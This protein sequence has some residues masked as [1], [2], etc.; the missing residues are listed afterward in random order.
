MRGQDF[1]PDLIP[2]SRPEIGDLE[3]LGEPPAAPERPQ[4]DREM[5]PA[6]A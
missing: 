6:S 1:T 4:E 2:R 3:I 5:L